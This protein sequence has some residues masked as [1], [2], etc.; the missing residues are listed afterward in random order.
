[1]KTL[2]GFIAEARFKVVK[3]YDS[4]MGRNPVVRWELQMD[5]KEIWSFPRKKDANAAAKWIES[6]DYKEYMKRPGGGE[7]KLG[8]V[9]LEALMY[10][11][12]VIK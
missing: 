8:Q 7:Y 5:G 10:K 3:E 4:P 12:G 1:M 6:G 11:A 9:D 2:K